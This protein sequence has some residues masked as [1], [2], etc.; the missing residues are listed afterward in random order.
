MSRS[1]NNFLKFSASTLIAA[2]LLAG[3]GSGSGGSA[4]LGGG[5]SVSPPPP[6]VTVTES[7]NFKATANFFVVG[8]PPIHARFLGGVANN[9]G[10]WVI[11]AGKT[12]V[13]D[14]GTPADAVKFATEDNFIAS[15][16]TV[17]NKPDVGAAQKMDPPFTLD[18][19]VRG[20][21][22]DSWAASAQNKMS[23][24]SDNVLALTI[25]VVAGTY[26]FKIA[27]AGWSGPT[28]CGGTVKNAPVPLGSAFT[29][30][31]DSGS[32]DMGLEITVDGDYKFTFDATGADKTAAKI[33]VAK[34][35]SGGGGGGEVPQDSTIIRIHSVTVVA[36][37]AGPAGVTSV[38]TVKGLGSLSVDEL[39]L[40]GDARITQIEIENTGTAGNV[41]IK[42]FRWT[43]DAQ[44]AL[45]KQLVD[46]YYSR[47]TGSV[48]G[49]KIVVGGK[50]YDC[51]APPAGSPFGCVAKNVEVTPYA[52]APMTVQNADGSTETIVF[53]GGSGAEDVYANSGTTL[54]S[55]G[56]PAPAPVIANAAAHWVD[57]GTLLFDPAAAVTKVE[58]LY[59]PDASIATGPQGI[60]GTY[61]TI[62]LTAGT[63]PQPA[64]NKQLHNL[65]AWSLPATVTVAKAKDIARGQ[66]VVI[67]RDA[68]GKV[69]GG[70]RVQSA[71]A[72]DALYA[73]AAYAAPL[74]V[75]YASGAPTLAVWAP[76]ALKDPGVSVNV[77]DAS[78]TKLETKAMTLDDATGIWSVT[79]TSDWDRKF[80]TISFQ[81]FSYAANA[82]VTN[83]ITD[84]YSVSLSTDSVRSQF[85]NLNDAD[86][87]PAGWDALVQPALAAPEDSVIYELQV[88][89]FSIADASVPAADRGKF[90]A[91]DDAGTNGRLHLQ[92]LAQAGLTH[93]HILPAFDIA[94][95]KEN[96]ADRV[97]LD[98]PVEAL[99]AKNAAAASL[100]DTDAGKTIRKAIEDAIAA[101]QLDRPPQIV[102]WMRQLDGFNWGYDPYHFGVPEGSYSSDPN[103]VARIL[104]FR[105]M[106]KGLNDIGL[107]TVMDVVYNHTNAS[108]QDNRSV[109]DKI[110]PG[111]YHRRDNK[112]GD[113]LGD[114]CCEDTASEFRMMEKLMID[115]GVR[116]VGD[117][118]VSGFRFDLM[119]FHPLTVMED[120][121]DAVKA[122]DPT[123]YI[124]GEGWN[125]GAIENDKRFVAARQANL[126]GTGIG[127]F[128]DRMRD[129]VRGGGPFDSGT[130]YVKNQGFIS[131]WFYDPNSENSGSTAE[132]EALIKASD[133][134]RVWLAGGLAGYQLTNA[135]G[136]LVSGAQ[137]D[138]S[139]QPSGYTQ[140]PQEAINYIDKHDNQTLWDY[141]AYKHPT[142][143]SIADRVRAQNVGQAVILL[144]QGVPFMQAGSDILRSKSGDRDSYD[145]GDWFNELDWTLSGT[146]WAQGLPVADKNSGEWPILLNKY[147]DLTTY[148]GPAQLQ[149]AFDHV[150][151]ML[152]IRKSSPLFR[153]QNEAEV[154]LRVKFYN[155][156]PSQ[157][158]G[159]IAMGIDGCTES[160]FVPT[161]GALMVI[162]NASD[163][164]RTL[165]LFGTE[166][167]TLHP[168]LAGST[169]PVVKTAKHDANGFFVPARTTAVFRRAAQ[170]SCAPPPPYP[171]DLYV[172]GSFNAWADPPLGQYKLLFLGGTA[173]SVT[174]PVSAGDQA[175]KVA[176]AA[177]TGSTNCGAS[178]ANQVVEIGKPALLACNSTSGNLSLPGVAAGDYVFALDASDVVNPTLTVTKAAPFAVDLYIRG[179]MNGWADPPPA[180]ARMSYDGIGKYR[181]T[182]SG[183]SAASYNFK[184]AD[185]GW[186][187]SNAGASNC[188][189][190][191]GGSAV[192][193][194]QPYSM[195]C[196]SNDN[197]ALTLP[198][199]GSYV[200]AADFGN[201]TAPSLTVT[202]AAF[203]VSVFLRGS[204][205]G[206]ADPPPDSA[207]LF[208]LGSG[209][210]A[211][212]LRLAPAAEAF[213]VA[214][215]SWNIFN[216]GG[217]TVTLGTPVTLS[218]G[219]SSPNTSF[220]VPA[221]G[222]YSF[223]LDATNPS[224][225]TVTVKG[226]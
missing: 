172:R 70:T 74:G 220:T 207:A 80:Y 102:Q 129:P 185:A 5:G 71:G 171:R 51:V 138:Y 54:A 31:C 225:P 156:G 197:M 19:F 134:I 139:G 55:T 212:T 50:T 99:C 199:A 140:D 107:R 88:R 124:Y 104:E 203:D 105:R 110:V 175:F 170:T 177:W 61:E 226:P 157:I 47:P 35:T 42:D 106:V 65:K 120:F 123:V 32:Q 224:A 210:L 137:V 1:F 82:I 23:E 21:V 69:L 166:A 181:V 194:G 6:P 192:T 98:D 176:D 48:V 190:S 30:L 17:A 95:V 205:N 3:C 100:C 198:T 155:T 180:S 221:D 91:F 183:L 158:P 24:V 37:A 150:R 40:A 201:P 182:L 141:G 39:R 163:D 118:K 208:E 184:V 187:G 113:V 147:L 108:G 202:R 126:G 142:G 96:Q 72:L 60:S 97:E 77:Y 16:G 223:T 143:T 83:E 56:T 191:A 121:Q 109:L 174:A 193:P 41:G 204:F 45:A 73:E 213:K 165:N 36:S 169:D 217:G 53:N 153:L 195:L 43:A 161:D 168:V 114:S 46:I 10:A 34:F 87:K 62:A 25:P 92:Q 122:V 206:W 89:D 86:L 78:G 103:G 164:P 149:R 173:Y 211:R 148:P 2:T 125:F 27:D 11:P 33:T 7:F 146:K 63:N 49:T 154:E 68:N 112:S 57:A 131:G 4:D 167:W 160:D 116:W 84:P 117:Y 26:A 130:Q 214:D 135:A 151:E 218:C 8:T 44:F 38:K 200:F 29:M 52:N 76:T 132:R 111:Y 93:V 144:G 79:G 85:V 162:F 64:F 159:V 115:T 178:V 145:S 209:L 9:N 196:P 179:E 186:G 216:C 15:S 67:G 127:S 189:A 12:G 215:A 219:G 18:M 188:G 20:S 59:S 101:N 133:N 81:V 58:L 136:V 14:F 94:T 128:S 119:S 13:V 90:T 75:I 152:R 222:Y 66:L 28:N 22:R